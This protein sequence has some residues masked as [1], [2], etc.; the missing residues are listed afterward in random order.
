MDKE[1]IINA[2]QEIIEER[3]SAASAAALTAKGNDRCS[4]S[5]TSAALVKALAL[6]EAVLS[7]IEHHD[8]KQEY[9]GKLVNRCDELQK[10][11][12][13]RL[14]PDLEEEATALQAHE[15]SAALEAAKEWSPGRV[16]KEDLAELVRPIYRDGWNACRK[17]HGFK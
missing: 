13:A 4:I 15:D 5:T 3:R 8:A 12:A 6:E 9:I 14:N 2:L 7:L 16:D 1:F 10:E 11:L 17:Y